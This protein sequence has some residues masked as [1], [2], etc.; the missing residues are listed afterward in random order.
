V[1]GKVLTSRQ[2][3]ADEEEKAMLKKRV[4]HVQGGSINHCVTM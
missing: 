3:A 2:P 4:A 1:S